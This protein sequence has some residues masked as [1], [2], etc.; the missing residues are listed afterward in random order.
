[1]RFWEV[2]KD[3]LPAMEMGHSFFGFGYGMPAAVGNAS[4]ALT[5]KA[6]RTQGP[7]TAV[8][9]TGEANR[10]STLPPQSGTGKAVCHK[11]S[12]CD[13]GPFPFR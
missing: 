11:T 1:M 9:M 7:G 6:I 4:A 13:A 12:D 8:P 10:P 3:L 2:G 5:G